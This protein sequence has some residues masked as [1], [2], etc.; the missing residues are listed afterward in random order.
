MENLSLGDDPSREEKLVSKDVADEIPP[1]PEPLPIR[2][3]REGVEET[4]YIIQTEITTDDSELSNQV[5]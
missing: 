1:P 2:E 3:T 4:E 5:T